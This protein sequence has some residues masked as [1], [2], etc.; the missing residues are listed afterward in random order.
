MYKPLEIDRENLT[1]MGV[2]FPD[3]ET[4]NSVA[5][6]IGSNM[7]EGFEPT[8]KLIRLYL[9]LKT[10]KMNNSELIKELQEAVDALN[11][12]KSGKGKARPA[13]ELL[14]EI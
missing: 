2:K 12:I 1:I 4:L 11:S 8:E 14:D 9:S 7:Y 10:K 3:L 5:Y 13:R 6:A